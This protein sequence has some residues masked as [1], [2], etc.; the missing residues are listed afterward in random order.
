MQEHGSGDSPK[1]IAKI[2]APTK[3]QQRSSELRRSPG[4]GDGGVSL[5]PRWGRGSSE[6]G[7]AHAP[8]PPILQPPR[9]LFGLF[10]IGL[11]Q[12]RP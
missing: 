7:S 5:K 4:N 10:L 3:L 11:K 2:K 9:N 8:A 12:A 6:S 1:A